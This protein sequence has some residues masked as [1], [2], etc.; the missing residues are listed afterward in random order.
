MHRPGI[1]LPCLPELLAHHQR[2]RRA[3]SRGGGRLLGRTGAYVAGRE[4]SRQRGHERL[5]RG[6][7]AVRIQPDPAL[8]QSA[9]GR[10]PHV[11][12]K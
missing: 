4:Q 3:F 11:A 1:C 9:V 10:G 2:G 8:H 5:V 12:Q 6:D 7:K